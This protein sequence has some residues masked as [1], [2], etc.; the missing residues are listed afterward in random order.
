[1]LDIDV[2]PYYVKFKECIIKMHQKLIEMLKCWMEIM[3][4]ISMLSFKHIS[5]HESMKGEIPYQL[6]IFGQEMF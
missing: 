4:I 1:M 5:E 6:I 2:K 3:K